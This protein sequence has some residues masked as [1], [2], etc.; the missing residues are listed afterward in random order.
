M[1]DA[2][3]AGFFDGEGYVR[4]AVWEKPN[5]SHTRYQV[6]AGIANTHR[7]IV[8]DL[9]REFGGTFHVNRHDL[10]K[11]TFRACFH[12]IVASQAAVV[13]FRRVLPH[14]IIKKE[15]VEL[16]LQLQENINAYKYKLGNQYRF[17]PDRD[18]IFA[19]RRRIA[20]EI[21]RLKHLSYDVSTTVG[22]LTAQ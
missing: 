2:Y 18:A 10:R 21:K 19:E 8:E 17:H 1:N 5:S 13:F 11:D 15:Q 14:L 9:Y 4:V 22:P 6:N 7:P 20:D 3:V 16:A 12:W